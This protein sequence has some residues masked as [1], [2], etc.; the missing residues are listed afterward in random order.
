[1]PSNN[2]FLQVSDL[3]VYYGGIHALHAV[4]MQVERGEIVAVIGANGAGKSTLLKTIAGIKSPTSG[5]LFLDGKPLPR[6]SYLAVRA[7]VTLVPEGRRIFAP[8][9]VKENLSLGAYSQ[10]D[11]VKTSR[12]MQEV[13]ALFPVLEE[14][15]SQ[16]GGTLSG[17]EQQM[18]AIGR[19]LMS[20]PRLLLLDE[21]SLGL[22]PKVVELLFDTIIQLNQTLGL[23]ILLVE[24]NASL[25]L[26]IS[27]RS[28]VLKTGRIVIEGRGQELLDDARVKESYLGLTGQD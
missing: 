6:Q 19:A 8:L 3:E 1:M 4:T 16:P 15:M 26:E 17:G 20:H 2:P 5:S 9:T 12:T 24:Q 28:F 18:L 25:A 7:G 13:C 23:T 27:H 21:P 22:A 11:A 14:R 10:N